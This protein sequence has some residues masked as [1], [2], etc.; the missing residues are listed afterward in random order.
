MEYNDIATM[1][2]IEL[3][4]WGGVA[5]TWLDARHGAPGAPAPRAFRPRPAGTYLASRSRPHKQSRDVI[6]IYI[7]IARLFVT[8]Q[9]ER[10]SG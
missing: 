3:Y 6:I 5:P 1:E 7:D 4:V 2:A 8:G 10:G 9:G